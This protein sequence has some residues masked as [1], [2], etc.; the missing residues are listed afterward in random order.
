MNVDVIRLEFMTTSDPNTYTRDEWKS[1]GFFYDRDDD[2]RLWMLQGSKGGLKRFASL[3]RQYVTNPRRQLKSEHEHY[4]PYMY[5]KISTWPEAGIRKSAIRGTLDDLKR[6]ANI[7]DNKLD[8]TDVGKSVDV[9]LDYVD[10]PEYKLVLCV[11]ADD[12]DPSSLDPL[13]AQNGG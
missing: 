6:L 5:L 12:T 9:S 1:L 8:E 3:L 11:C 4:G 2:A 7:V 13:L 10:D